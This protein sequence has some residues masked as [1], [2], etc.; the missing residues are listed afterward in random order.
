MIDPKP[1]HAVPAS[2]QGQTAGML[3]PE[4]PPRPP[5]LSAAP[6]ALG[7]L[8]ALRRRWRI[9]FALGLFLAA[10][11]GTATW[12][13][14]PQAKY[15]ACAT[16]HVSTNPKYIIFDP[17]ERL[18]DY[19]TYQRTQVEMAKSRFVLAD[20]LKKP[21]VAGLTTIREYPDAEEWLAQ[22]IKISFPNT[23]E[24]LEISLSGYHPTD[25]AKLVNAVVDSYM[26]RVVDEEQKERQA[27]LEK[28][29][30]LWKR[31]Q[32]NLQAKRKE[33][34]ELSETIGSNDKQTLTI[35]HQFKIQH[36]DVAQREQMQVKFELKKAEAELT[37]LESRVNAVNGISVSS[38]TIDEQVEVLPDILE[39]KKQVRM[40]TDQYDRVAAKVRSKNDP[41][42][43]TIRR[44]LDAVQRDLAEYRAKVRPAI[45]AEIRK[46]A[47]KD[48]L[49]NLIKLRAQISVAKTY[50]DT[51]DK[52]IERLQEETKVINLG[53]QDL[54]QQQDEI[55]IV[56]ET[57]RKIGAEVEAM[58]V[59]LGA[60]PRIHVVD[61]ATVPTEKDKFRKVKASGTA[62]V[63]T[64]AIVLLGVSFWEFRARRID[65]VDQVAQGLGLRIVGTLPAL[66]NCSRHRAGAE[67]RRL[68]SV[69]IES[70]DA[71]RTIILHASRIEAIR[72]VMITSAVKGEG[73]T[74]L[75]V[76]LS[77][78]LARAGRRTLLI[79]CDLRCPTAHRLFDLPSE[80]GMSE[81][82][83]G[84]VDADDVIQP[85]PTGGLHLI[86]AGQ[87]DALAI[88]AL[89]QDRIRAAFD[90]LRGRYDFI[91]VDS[92]PVLPVADSLLLSQVVDAV[93][94]SILR[95]VSQVPKVYAAH[96]RLA[97]LGARILGAV[98]NGA[99]GESYGSDYQY[100]SQADN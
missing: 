21:E 9:G 55:Q 47:L 7:L 33:M 87:C 95:D 85:T 35:A 66:P 23:S 58:E 53:S 1:S 79:D 62:S 14:T 67:E 71:A 80:P 64:F 82:L 25:L 12:Y 13:L 61:R 18:A 3:A 39:L 100:A 30:E 59:E 45:A 56:S 41:A 74:S 91:I 43:L 60:P 36:L 72:M 32:D 16:L 94:F 54:T 51:I 50:K 10:V 37:V 29:K 11:A 69:L 19:R 84:E 96:E 52:D 86:P 77:T 4:T 81:V 46:A 99:T 42:V 97:L 88:Q 57:A 27:R 48:D 6:D 28:L 90:G 78:S 89:A 15:T 5:A 49:A 70:I 76:H 93:I 92:A 65:T 73:K 75:S 20:A 98:V 24:V 8:K 83:R 2:L 22:Q 34:R 38:A 44:R 17:K 63:G 26:S 40:L 31:Y 68:Q